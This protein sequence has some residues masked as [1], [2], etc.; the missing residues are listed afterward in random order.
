[1]AF[2]NAYLPQIATPDQQDRVS[3][4]G[5]AYGYVGCVTLQLICFLFIFKPEWF[6]IHDASFPPRLSFLLVGVWWVSFAQITFRF[7]PKNKPSIQIKNRPFIAQVK[8]EFSSVWQQVRKV[9]AIRRFLPAYFFYAMGIQT[10]LIVAAAFGEKVLQLGASKLIAS[11]LL[12]QIVAIGGAYLM[13]LLAKKIG[14]I[15]V[16]IAVVFCWILICVASY[17][18]RHEYHFYLM[19]FAVGLLMGGIQSLSRSTYSKLIPEHVTDTTAFFSFYDVTEK[20]AIVIGLF[21]FGII[22]QI[23][24]NIRYSALFLSVFF[25]IGFLL[26]FRVLKFN[27]LQL[28]QSN[29]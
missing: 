25:I 1:M 5:F 19:A 28:I 15:K 17:Y 11:I 20:F 3:A 26:L 2:N 14:N 18:M 6:G 10:L 21:S 12:I 4:Q 9:E 22:E 29:Q 13:S 27:N 7:L 8:Q 24:H 23:T 16:L